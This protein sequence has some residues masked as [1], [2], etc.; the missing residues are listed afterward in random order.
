LDSRRERKKAQT[1]AA[2]L[3]AAAALFSEL[4]INATR[5]EDITN[6]IDLGKGAF[7]NYFES[8][9]ALVAELVA[10]GITVLER[11]Y[12]AQVGDQTDVRERVE[13]VARLHWAFLDE[14]PHYA[15]L[16]HQA[17]GLLHFRETRVELLREV[18]SGYLHRLGAIIAPP[19][20]GPSLSR[21]E[22]LGVSAAVAGSIEGYRSLQAAAG[23]TAEPELPILALA[24]GIGVLLDRRR[25]DRA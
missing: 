14:Y 3:R 4:G 21:E 10:E 23:L 16:F 20:A 25:L 22:L 8:K 18:F 2:L 7:Y 11:D 1:R 13:R 24:A 15:I 6:K 9:D 5:V 19:G 17:R 12:L